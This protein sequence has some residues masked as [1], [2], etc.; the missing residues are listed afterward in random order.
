MKIIEFIKRNISVLNVVAILLLFLV[1]KYFFTYDS[2]RDPYGLGQL[3]NFIGILF[4][5]VLLLID[6][7]TRKYNTSRFITNLVSIFITIF[8]III[9]FLT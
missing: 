3:I 9:Y 8:L 7:L 4:V 2:Y 5:I 1:F 6:Y